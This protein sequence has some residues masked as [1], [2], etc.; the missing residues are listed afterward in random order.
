M[1]NYRLS[2]YDRKRQEELNRANA[3]AFWLA[4]PIVVFG[5]LWLLIRVLDWVG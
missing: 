2:E 1:T 3:P 5:G 4:F